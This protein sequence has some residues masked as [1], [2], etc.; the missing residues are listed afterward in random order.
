MPLPS[1]STGVLMAPFGDQAVLYDPVAGQ[2]HVLNPTARVVWEGC[3]LGFELDEVVEL[4]AT[5]SGT[6]P[7]EV[8]AGVDGYLLDLADARLV[9]SDE[10]RP[11]VDP[12]APVVGGDRSSSVFAV[13]DDG[14]V[15]RS[16]D[17]AICAAI[18][19]AL[20]PLAGSVP[21]SVEIG[22][23]VEP[24]GAVT[25]VGPTAELGWAS[26]GQFLEELPTTLNQ[27][28]AAS[29]TVL[30]LH[31]GAVVSPSGAV[32]LLPAVSGSG[33]TT[34]TA[35]L[36]QA[37]W[38]YLTDEAAGVRQGSLQ[39]VSY[40]KPLVL[41]PASAAALG[42]SGRSSVN[43][44]VDELRAGATV[45]AEAVGP[46]TAVVLPRYEAG[47]EVELTPLEGV[48]AFPALAEHALNLR[49]VGRPGF[50]A[51]V[52]LARRVPCHR[53]LHGGGASAVEAVAALTERPDGPSPKG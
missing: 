48:D 46:V 13:L 43:V 17:A 33:K 16:E 21:V 29:T 14:V 19:G 36:V 39:P 8:A 15:F 41:D 27:I 40:A 26:V 5:A 51:L 18:D 22:V 31:S 3:D 49:H 42:L 9:G 6:D 25:V 11:L 44:A 12:P 24:D 28:A 1:P 35:A 45:A 23:L 10:W 37:G 52:D 47:A 20:G 4:L 50:E 38:G 2:V 30:A 34:L 32:V 7:V 53:L